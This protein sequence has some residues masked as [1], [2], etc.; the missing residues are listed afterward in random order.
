MSAE[1]DE[2]GDVKLRI[3]SFWSRWSFCTGNHGDA[4]STLADSDNRELTSQ[5]NHEPRDCQIKRKPAR[6]TGPADFHT[7]R[8]GGYCQLSGV[9]S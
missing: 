6:K 3:T 9:K 8:V 4:E 5:S 2:V 1:P 7:E